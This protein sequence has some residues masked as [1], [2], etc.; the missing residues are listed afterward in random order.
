MQIALTKRLRA[1]NII[2]VNNPAKKIDSNK[3]NA[4]VINKIICVILIIGLFSLKFLN[5]IYIY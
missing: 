1:A 5:L 2:L 4:V 3:Y